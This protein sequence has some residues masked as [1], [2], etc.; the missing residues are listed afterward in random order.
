MKKRR[1]P[2]AINSHKQLASALRH[3]QLHKTCRAPQGPSFTILPSGLRCDHAVA[4]EALRRGWLSPVDL[5][6]FDP[7]T[8][9][10]WNLK[11]T[12][13]ENVHD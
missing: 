12:E 5:G 4:R 8:A 11:I 7:D 3:V 13:K 9:Q 2:Y 6:L 1:P 10:S